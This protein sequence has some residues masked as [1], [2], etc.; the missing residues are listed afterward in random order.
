VRNSNGNSPHQSLKIGLIGHGAASGV[1]YLNRD[2]AEHLAV[3]TWFVTEQPSLP[4]FHAPT[5][6]ARIVHPRGDIETGVR[7]WLRDLDWVVCAENIPIDCLP[8]LAQET[9]TRVACVPMWEWTSPTSEWLHA[10]DLLICPTNHAYDLFADWKRRFSFGWDLARF[11]WP[12]S[13]E[14]FRFRLRERCQRF[15]FVNGHGGAAAKGIDSGRRLVA[16]KGLD[17]VLAAAARTPDIPWIVYTQADLSAPPSANV[18]VRQGPAT[19]EQLYEDGDVCVQPSRWEG[20]GL[21]LL[22]CQ[23]AGMPLVVMD[24]PPMNEYHPLRVVEPSFWQWGFLLEGQPVRIP[25]VEHEVLADLCRELHGSD[26]RAASLAAHEWTHRERSWPQSVGSWR[27]I[28]DSAS[29][30]ER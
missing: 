1:G 24:V 18:E 12:V 20:I 13:S 28:F 25:G 27:S 4:V 5:T 23:M 30:A 3:D 9:G 2:L 6:G 8:R 16:R 22:E 17:L 10:V 15:V 21:P 11:P 7:N 26:I 19:H 29:E 14:R